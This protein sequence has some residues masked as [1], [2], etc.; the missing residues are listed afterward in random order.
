MNIGSVIIPAIMSVIIVYGLVKKVDIFECFITG[1]KEG[2]GTAVAIL[3]ALVALMTCV[4]MFKASGVLDVVTFSFAPLAGLLGIPKEIIPLAIL[5]PISGSGALVIFNNLLG[6]FGPDSYIG[7][8]ASV[9]EGSSETTFYTIAV[10][11]G[12]IKLSK[13]RHTVAASLTADVAGFVMSAVMVTWF[14]GR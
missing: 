10:Y 2:L 5:R 4:G 1:A 8:V 6:E 13:T 11:F 9:L 3:P 14:F 7:R 12:A